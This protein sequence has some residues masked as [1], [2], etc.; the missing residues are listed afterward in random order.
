MIFDLAKKRKTT[1]IFL[2]EKVNIEDIK[3][4]INVA[5]EAPSGMNSQPWHFVIVDDEKLKEKIRKSVEEKEKIFYEKSKGKLKDFLNEYNITWQKSFLTEAPYLILVYSDKRFPFS[6]ES[7]WISVGYLLLALE[8][9]GLS[10]LTYTPPN[11]QDFNFS[12]YK[13][14]VI[15]PVGHGNDPKPKLKRKDLNEIISYNKI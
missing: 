10:S 11:P 3:Y 7:T 14:E 2:N 9:K 12:T 5:K 13:L 15:I 6:K 1:R 4:A 8:E